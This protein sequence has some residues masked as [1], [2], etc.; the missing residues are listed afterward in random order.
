M[1]PVKFNLD[2][3]GDSSSK[4]C[5]LEVD[6]EYTKELNKLHNDYPVA[7]DKLEIKK[8]IFSDY[9][10]F[11]DNYTICL[12]NIKKLVPNLFDKGKYVLYCKT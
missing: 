6:L 9:Q 7:P 2:K 8:E 10:K 5:A 12:G 3:Y 11:A 4:S 1:D